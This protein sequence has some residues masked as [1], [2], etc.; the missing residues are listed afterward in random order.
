MPCSVY[1]CCVPCSFRSDHAALLRLLTTGKRTTT[2]SSC[3]IRSSL[4]KRRCVPASWL[5]L[6]V[7][8]LHGVM[9]FVRAMGCCSS[10]PALPASR[11]GRAAPALRAR[12]ALLP[13]TR[14]RCWRASLSARTRASS[15][16]TTTPVRLVFFKSFAF[17]LPAAELRGVCCV[18]LAAC[19]RARAYAFI[20]HLQ[21]LLC[22]VL[23]PCLLA[24]WPLLYCCASCLQPSWR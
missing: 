23:S 7:R 14:R 13:R 24:S 21:R 1:A 19:N 4:L 17:P 8:S 18:V 6:A 20:V 16:R 22:R 2:R 11:S 3:A 12:A 5:C 15:L 9:R 10:S